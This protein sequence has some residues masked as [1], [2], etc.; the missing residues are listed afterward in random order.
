MPD[1]HDADESAARPG[2][3]TNPASSAEVTDIDGEPVICLRGDIDLAVAEVVWKV[4]EPAIP[5]EGRLIFDLAAT[6]FM[7]STGLS[8]IVRA[9]QAHP[10]IVVRSPSRPVLRILMLTG[11]DELIT[12]EAGAEADNDDNPTEEPIAG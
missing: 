8:V 7:D 3:D 2:A 10:N 4:V 11:I 1:Q 9:H 6:T 12:V 5:A